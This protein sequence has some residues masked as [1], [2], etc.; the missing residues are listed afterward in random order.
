[1]SIRRGPRHGTPGNNSTQWARSNVRDTEWNQQ[2]CSAYYL[3]YS[4]ECIMLNAI[5]RLLPLYNFYIRVS[6][7]V[8]TILKV[9]YLLFRAE[10]RIS[11]A[12]NNSHFIESRL[13][14]SYK[15]T[16]IIPTNS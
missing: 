13:R 10:N 9:I 12:Q 5:N 15:Q 6:N 2:L 4:V 11:V 7:F 8:S 14:G 3:I 16:L 1:M